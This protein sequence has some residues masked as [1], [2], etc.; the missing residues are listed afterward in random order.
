VAQNEPETAAECTLNWNLKK[1][2][3]HQNPKEIDLR[4]E[5]M[6][7]INEGPFVRLKNGLR[8]LMVSKDIISESFE[9]VSSGVKPDERTKANNSPTS[10]ENQ[11]TPTIEG[12]QAG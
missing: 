9:F 5:L 11:G 10:D 1:A 2:V 4:E 12:M 6:A 7:H 3:N 8:H